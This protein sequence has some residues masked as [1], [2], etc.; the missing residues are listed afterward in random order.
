MLIVLDQIEIHG[1]I[2]TLNSIF[3]RKPV[4]YSD[5]A[6]LGRL[7]IEGYLFDPTPEDSSRYVLV[8]EDR[9][10]VHILDDLSYSMWHTP[11]V[12]EAIPHLSH[13]FDIFMYTVGDADNSYEFA[14]YREGRLARRCV[15]DDTT[16]GQSEGVVVEDN[17]EPLPLELTGPRDS[18]NWMWMRSI[19][20][21]L[22]IDLRHRRDQIRAYTREY[23]SPT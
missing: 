3:F 1:T 15:V 14:Y 23:Q 7:G 21:S 10:W 5:D 8:T 12:H 16:W 2:L 13:E 11:S 19:A 18:D 6:L 17:G 4:A 9:E 20:G 22:G